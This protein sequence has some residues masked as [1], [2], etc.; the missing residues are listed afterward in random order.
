MTAAIV[1]MLTGCEATPQAELS[2]ETAPPTTAAPPPP[3]QG[4]FLAQLSPAV[5]QQLDSLGVPIAVPTSL[6]A[7]MSLV[8][9][10]SRPAPPYYLL[11]YRD[12]R[13]R[14]FAIEFAPAGNNPAGASQTLP[15]Q[16]PQFANGE[17]Q[18]HY[19]QAPAASQL[20]SD[21]LRGEAGLYRLVGAAYINERLQGQ[22]ACQDITPDEAVQIINSMVYLNGGEDP[23]SIDG[24]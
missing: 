9:V 24:S 19:S 11:I 14:C 10:E 5:K 12:N 4:A 23:L 15:L 13:D 7:E 3:P 16:P 17:Y 22:A 2:S 8:A 6:P 20:R 21:W 1:L 18:L